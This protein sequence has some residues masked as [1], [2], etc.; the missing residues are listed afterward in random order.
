M[1]I[2][3]KKKCLQLSNTTLGQKNTYIKDINKIQYNFSRS[4][5]N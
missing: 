3:A 5:K 4:P 2:Y 1:K